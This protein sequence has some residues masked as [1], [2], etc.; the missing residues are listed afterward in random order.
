MTIIV[1]SVLALVSFCLVWVVSNAVN[2]LIL[3]SPFATLDFLLKM[4]RMAVLSV[5]VLASAS[6]HY[7]MRL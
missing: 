6:A 5:L 1:Y 3:I 4:A 7:R 2:I